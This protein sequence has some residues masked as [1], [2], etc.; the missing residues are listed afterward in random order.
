MSAPRVQ[1]KESTRDRWVAVLPHGAALSVDRSRSWRRL[2]QTKP[3][4]VRVL[5]N[6]FATREQ[7]A[8]A[9]EAMAHAEKMLWTTAMDLA[10]LAGGAS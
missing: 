7:F 6:N 9:P 5:G 10:A 3:W 2:G 4:R 8:T 1:W